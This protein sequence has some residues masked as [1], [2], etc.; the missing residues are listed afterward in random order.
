MLLSRE[1][2][3]LHPGRP[4]IKTL[5]AAGAKKNVLL[6]KR[7]AMTLTNLEFPITLDG[8]KLNINQN[9]RQQAYEKLKFNSHLKKSA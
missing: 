3:E 5:L 6:S 2:K 4:P 8:L 7:L 1:Q 9:A